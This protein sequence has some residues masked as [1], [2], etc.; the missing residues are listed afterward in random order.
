MTDETAARRIAELSYQTQVD[1]AKLSHS[2]TI[3]FAE[4]TVQS[5]LILNGGAAVAMSAL[6]GA[7]FKDGKIG[8]PFD[9]VSNSILALGLGAVFAVLVPGLAYLAQ[10][11]YSEQIQLPVEKQQDSHFR[12]GGNMFRVLA[13]GAAVMSMLFFVIGLRWVASMNLG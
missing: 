9:Q 1:M 6:L 8:I 4:I 11:C 13:V 3:R 7:S 10:S 2:S 12:F 5:L